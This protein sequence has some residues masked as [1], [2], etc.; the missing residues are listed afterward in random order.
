MQEQRRCYTRLSSLARNVSMTYVPCP[1]SLRPTWDVSCNLRFVS[2]EMIMLMLLKGH[3]IWLLTWW[4][5]IRRT[6]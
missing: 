5:K 3:P 4:L 6:L 1:N 2:T